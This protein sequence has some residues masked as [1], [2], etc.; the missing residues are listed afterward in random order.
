[1]TLFFLNILLAVIW[2]TLWNS[3]TLLTLAGG[4]ALGFAALWLARGLL[5]PHYFRAVPAVLALAGFFIVELVKSCILVAR[6]CIAPRP[7]IHPAIVRMPLDVRSDAE[8]FL[9]ANL[10]TLTPGTLT[11]DVAA[12][13]SFLLIHA[14]Y[15]TDEAALVAELK[16]GMEH[17]V[18]KVFGT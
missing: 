14:I 17:R 8:I 5:A 1:M 6:D 18:R 7:N 2:A 9:L 11:L 15:A 12:D 3:F 4:F 16:A 10:I 13:R